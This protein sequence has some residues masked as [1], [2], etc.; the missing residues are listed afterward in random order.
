MAGQPD[1]VTVESWRSLQLDIQVCCPSRFYF[2][3][4]DA[5]RLLTSK[6]FLQPDSIRTVQDALARISQ[7]QV[8]QVGPSDSGKASEQVTVLRVIEALPPVLVLHLK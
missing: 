8:V 2:P 4:T 3:F 5:S 1:S 7:P 6:R